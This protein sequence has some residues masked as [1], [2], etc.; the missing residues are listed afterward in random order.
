VDEDVFETFMH[1]RDSLPL[2]RFDCGVNDL[3][4]KYNRIL[5][6]KLAAEGI[7]HI[8]EEHPGGHEWPY[9]ARHIIDSLKFFAQTL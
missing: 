6:T 7:T 9:W 1:Y 4:I 3:L 8:Y 2:V 5:H